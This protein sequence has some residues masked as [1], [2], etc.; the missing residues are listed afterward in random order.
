M[1]SFNVTT[2][3]M[4]D[5]ELALEEIKLRTKIKTIEDSI[6]TLPGLKAQLKELEGGSS[7]SSSSPG[8]SKTEAPAATAPTKDVSFFFI[9]DFFFAALVHHMLL[10]S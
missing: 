10:E 1:A 9:V 8:E 6:K 5:D 2:A 7:S 3:D 4:Q